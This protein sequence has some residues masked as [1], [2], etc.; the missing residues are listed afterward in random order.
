MS[1]TLLQLLVVVAGAPLLSG[2]MRQVRARL[3]GRAGAGVLQPWRDLRKLLRKEPITPHGTGWVFRSAPA[4]LA[5][6][7]LVVAAVV[8]LVTTASPLDGVADLFAVAALLA[9]GSVALALAGLDTGTAFGGMG[10]SR[11]MVVL[12]LVEPTIL[13]SVFA[14]SIP[15]GSTNLA[16]IVTSGVDLVSP[17]SLLVAAALAVVVLAET[18]RVPVDNPSTHLELT[19]IHEAMVLEYSGPDLALIEWAEAVRLAVLLG[20]VGSLFAPAGIAGAGAG[21]LALG[22]AVAAFALKTALLGALLAAGEVF[23]AKLRLFRIPE[24]L[25]GSFLMALLAVAA[26]YFL[27]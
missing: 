5:A 3:E 26:S 8:P 4:V 24:L 17:V 22:V 25:A 18:G 6:T 14:L 21:V 19:M 10:A 16:A 23:M 2:L 1:G 9:L 13:L 20:L 27:T 7:A 11:E 15:A 12:A